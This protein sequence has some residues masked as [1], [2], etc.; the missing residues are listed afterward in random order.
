MEAV[1]ETANIVMH[2]RLV[3]DEIGA[4]VLTIKRPENGGAAASDGVCGRAKAALEAA[5]VVF[6]DGHRVRLREGKR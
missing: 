1:M 3:A 5:G 4:A 2:H 6:V